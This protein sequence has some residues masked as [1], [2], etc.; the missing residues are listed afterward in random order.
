MKGAPAVSAV[1][2]A[3]FFTPS[4]YQANPARY[5]FTTFPAGEGGL[6]AATG[7]AA[8][9]RFGWVNGRQVANIRLSDTDPLGVVILPFVSPYINTWQRNYWDEVSQTYRIRQ[10]TEVQ[11]LTRGAVWVRFAGGAWPGQKVYAS[12]VD[13]QAYS[14]YA[15]DAQ[16][17]SWT[18]VEQAAPGG[19]ALISTFAF[20]NGVSTP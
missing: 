5:P 2:G 8:I 16:L 11:L 20:F 1:E 18:V 10:G 12:I 19:L 6:V 3:L 13:G 9:G 15:D 4:Q 14:G 7:G 17:T